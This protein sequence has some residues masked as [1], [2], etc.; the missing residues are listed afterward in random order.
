[1]CSMCEAQIL[2]FPT[3]HLSQILNTA[4][5]GLEAPDYFWIQDASGIGP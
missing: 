1:M 5:C 4:K 2:V 3:L